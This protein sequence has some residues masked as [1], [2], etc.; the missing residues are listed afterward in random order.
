MAG[1]SFLRDRR[2]APGDPSGKLPRQTRSGRTR[3]AA[4]KK[5]QREHGFYLGAVRGLIVA[6]RAQIKRMR[7]EKAVIAAIRET[8][9]LRKG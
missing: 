3:S 9:R 2:K 5:Q 7:A 6:Q 4:R 8:K 1:V